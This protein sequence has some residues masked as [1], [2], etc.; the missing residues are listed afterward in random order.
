MSTRTF[1]SLLLLNN[2]YFLIEIVNL[3]F[4]VRTLFS[5]SDF[6]RSKN[7]A[8]KVF[9]TCFQNEVWCFTSLPDGCHVAA[10]QWESQKWSGGETGQGTF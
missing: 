5:N 7:L 9:V 2:D 10:R 8:L 6:S 4:H 3:I 1:F